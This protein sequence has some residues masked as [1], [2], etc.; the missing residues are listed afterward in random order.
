MNTPNIGHDQLLLNRV[1]F[2]FSGGT[3]LGRKRHDGLLPELTQ[4]NSQQRGKQ[5]HRDAVRCGLGS[6]AN[7]GTG[8]RFKR[9]AKES[10]LGHLLRA[11]GQVRCQA[12]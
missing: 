4:S 10:G 11:D 5:K 6:W 3:G 12:F 1:Y 8:I 2:P 7:E 9:D